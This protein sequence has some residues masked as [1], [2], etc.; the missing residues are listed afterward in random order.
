VTVDIDHL[1]MLAGLEPGTDERERVVRHLADLQ[2]LV[3]AL[4]EEVAASAHPHEFLL[5]MRE[6]EPA[7]ALRPEEVAR[8]MAHR[9]GTWLDVPPVREDE[10]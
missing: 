5:P 7:A 9:S 8:L 4:P 6:D 3:D 1:A 10:P 2:Q